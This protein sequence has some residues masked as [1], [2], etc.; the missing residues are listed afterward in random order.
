MGSVKAMQDYLGASSSPDLDAEDAKGVSC[1]GHAVGANR[2]AVVKLLLAKKAD[3]AACDASG[4]T[5]LH[6][7]AAYGRKE[8]LELF[9]K[10]GLA[11]NAKTVA[12]YTP[13]ALATKNKQSDAMALL[14]SKGGEM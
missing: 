2:I 11:I 7:A 10:G 4:G 3:P 12:G 5:A 13:L 6:Y 14:K 9:V 1:L 8:L